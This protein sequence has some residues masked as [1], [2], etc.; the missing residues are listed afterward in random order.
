MSLYRDSAAAV[1]AIVL[2]D[3]TNRGRTEQGT[4][5]LRES[6]VLV[7]AAQR[8]TDDMAQREYLVHTSPDG[9]TPWYW[10]DGLATIIRMR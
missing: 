8:K 9:K 6:P 1:Y 10:L 7:D 2:V 3:L 4:L 5:S